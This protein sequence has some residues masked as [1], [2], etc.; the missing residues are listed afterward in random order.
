[1]ESVG[2]FVE[3]LPV[4]MRR[5][6]SMLI[7]ESLYENVDFLIGKQERFISWMCPLLQVRVTAPKEIIYYE[8][9]VL[10]NVYFLKSGS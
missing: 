1:M 5:P 6:L 3:E 2:K 10:S 7:Y 8:N 9:D 4:E